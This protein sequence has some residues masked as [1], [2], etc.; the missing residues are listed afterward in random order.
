MGE[1]SMAGFHGGILI[2]LSL[3]PCMLGRLIGLNWA[4]ETPMHNEL[5]SADSACCIAKQAAVPVL[6][7]ACALLQ[8][9]RAVC[10][11]LRV[12]A[13]KVA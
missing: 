3:L 11:T 4:V 13:I 8:A 1:A 12:W 10:A 7:H 5:A 2:R 9:Q 6:I